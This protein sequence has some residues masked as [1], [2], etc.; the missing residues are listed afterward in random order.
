MCELKVES[1]KSKEK[2]CFANFFTF[3]FMDFIDFWLTSHTMWCARFGLFPFRSPLLRKFLLVSFPLGTEMFH[4]P[5]SSSITLYIQVMI[6]KVFLVGF[7]HSEISGSKVA[8]HLP[9]A[10]RRLLRPSSLVWVKAFTICINITVLNFLS[11]P[12]QSKNQTR[13]AVSNHQKML[14]T[15]LKF[16][17]IAFNLQISIFLLLKKYWVTNQ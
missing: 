16:S 5:R 11:N 1:R 10:Y 2:I 17:S 14:P 15:Y 4:F 9:E 12:L 8:S 13:L 7:P 3:D 6:T